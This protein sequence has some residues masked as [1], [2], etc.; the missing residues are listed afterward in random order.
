[1]AAVTTQVG[2]W[3]IVELRARLRDACPR[4]AASGWPVLCRTQY[5]E[6]VGA[7]DRKGYAGRWVGLCGALIALA[8]IGGDCASATAGRGCAGA[9]ARHSADAAS[10]SVLW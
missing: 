1:M 2:E 4:A 6:V 5:P 3:G 7:I 9:D 8:P 10:H